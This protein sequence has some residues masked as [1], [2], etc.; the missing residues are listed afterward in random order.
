M[1]EIKL[2][3]IQNEEANKVLQRK[4]QLEAALA[5]VRDQE[6]QFLR[7]VFDQHGLNKV[8]EKIR[9]ED[10]KLFFEEV[11]EQNR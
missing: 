2:T 7:L 6:S 4:G 10:G 9:L 11:E 5:A 8:P 1:K 3:P